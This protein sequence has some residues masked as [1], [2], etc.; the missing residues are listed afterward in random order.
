MRLLRPIRLLFY[1][2]LILFLLQSL[3]FVPPALSSDPSSARLEWGFKYVHVATEILVRAG[4]L[5]CVGTAVMKGRLS[6]SDLCIMFAA[7]TYAI[8]VVSRGLIL[9]ILIYF[10]FAYILISY[11]KYSKFRIR[12]KHVFPFIAI[13]LIFVIYG[14]WRQGDDFSIS[15]YGGMLIDSNAIAWVFGY[16][17]VNL[18]NLALVI[19]ENFKNDSITNVFGPLLQ[20]LQILDYKEIDDYPYVGKFNLGTALRPFVIDYGPWLG[21]IAFALIWS[22]VLLLPNLCY[23]ASTRIAI[24]ISLAYMS[25]LFPV[26][27]R[28]E[29]PPYLIPLLLIIL[30][31]RLYWIRRNF[32]FGK[33]FKSSI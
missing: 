9:E 6:F 2:V 24:V 28:M 8:L 18:D 20:S 10:A 32:L 22:L 5:A 4:V 31:D 23:F 30:S 14:E 3:I 29:Q 21:G 19:M 16:F 25:L 7:E 11:R 15:E 27:G 26:T 33:L 13:W 17:F 12:S 1:F